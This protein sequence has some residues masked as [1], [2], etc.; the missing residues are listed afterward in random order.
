[1]IRYVWANNYVGNTSHPPEYEQRVS[2]AKEIIIR[3]GIEL[4]KRS[5]IIMEKV[6]VK[7]NLFID[8]IFALNN[9]VRMKC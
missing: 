7:L 5:A 8:V 2:N 4:Q 3:T 6:T 1:M 9:D